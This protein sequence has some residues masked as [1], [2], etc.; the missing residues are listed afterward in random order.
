M[1]FIGMVVIIVQQQPEPAPEPVAPVEQPEP[2]RLIVCQRC[3]WT[4]RHTDPAKAKQ[5]LGGHSRFCKGSRGNQSPFSRSIAVSVTPPVTPQPAPVKT[6]ACDV[7]GWKK[8][9]TTEKR[10]IEGLRVHR[11]QNHKPE[12]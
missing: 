3:G 1:L 8:T 7:C 6:A 12:K 9:F 4:A 11:K 2:G 10:A 5:A